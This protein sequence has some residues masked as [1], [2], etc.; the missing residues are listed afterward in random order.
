MGG[1]EAGI[2]TV[3][4]SRGVNHLGDF[5]RFMQQQSVVAGR[6]DLPGAI[7]EHYQ[8]RACGGLAAGGDRSCRAWL[9]GQTRDGSIRGDAADRNP[10]HDGQHPPG[11]KRVTGQC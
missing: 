6:G 2:E 10:S 9:T 3:S 5:H 1:E 4:G 11:K 8:F 7:R